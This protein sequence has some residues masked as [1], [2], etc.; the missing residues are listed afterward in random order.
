[1]SNASFAPRWVSSPGN[2]IAEALE[3]KG[4]SVRQFA[5]ELGTSEK[6]A[7]SLLSGV[8]TINMDLAQNLARVIGSTPAFWIRREHFYRQEVER[9]I[10][11]GQRWLDDLPLSDM[12]RLGWIPRVTSAADRVSAC[13]DFFDVSDVA[14]WHKKYDNTLN[15]I[16]FKTSNSF[17]SN[18]G[19]V[20]AWI[21]HAEI[22]AED[23]ECSEWNEVKFLEILQQLRALTRLKSPSEFIPEL[24]RRCAAAGVAVVVARAPTGCRAS[25]ATK[26]LA[27]GNPLILLSFRHLSEDHF[28]FAFYHEAGHVVLHGKNGLFVEGTGTISTPNEDEANAFAEKALI[29]DRYQTELV[30]LQ[31][32]KLAIA[33]FAR[34]IGVSAGI[35]VGQ[36]QHRGII[37][38]SRLNFLKRRFRW[39]T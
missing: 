20:A 13:L 4:V 29:P 36:L 34:K 7:R 31:L 26:F 8:L 2:T 18:P 33:R 6:D 27:R 22:L 28:W 5:K 39:T 14:N 30:S 1:M 10:G 24:Q 17:D 25:G 21:R 11:P 9:L 35:V 19:A 38:H 3:R 23:L 15:R 37:P 32:N 16:A 12:M